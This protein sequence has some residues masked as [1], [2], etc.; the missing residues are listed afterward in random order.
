MNIASKEIAG[1]FKYTSCA[2]NKN[3]FSHGWNT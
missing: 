1:M 2:Y 3:E